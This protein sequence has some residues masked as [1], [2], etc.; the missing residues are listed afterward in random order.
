MI[1]SLYDNFKHWSDKSLT[2][3]IQNVYIAKR[4]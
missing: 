3:I 2:N 4:N 1:A